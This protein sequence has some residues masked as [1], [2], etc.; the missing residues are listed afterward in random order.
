MK[1]IP[2]AAYDGA[3]VLGPVVGAFQKTVLGAAGQRNAPGADELVWQSTPAPL[4]HPAPNRIQVEI[5]SHCNMLC[6]FCAYTYRDRATTPDQHMDFVLF[7]K[8]IDECKS[9]LDNGWWIN[10]VYL[11]GLGEPLLYDRFEDA[12]QYSR[13]TAPNGRRLLRGLSTNCMALTERKAA[14]ILD[15]EL[16]EVILS[17]DSIVKEEYER[18]RVGGK[19]ETVLANIDR[20]LAM[21]AARGAFAEKVYLQ[22]MAFWENRN[23]IVDAARFWLAKIDGMPN[24]VAHLKQVGHWPAIKMRPLP[25]EEGGPVVGK[26]APPIAF[27]DVNP[28]APGVPFAG[29]PGLE[30]IKRHD[31]AEVL[32]HPQLSLIRE[33]ADIRPSCK[34]WDNSIT[35]LASGALDVCCQNNADVIGVGNVRDHTMLE[36]WRGERW[37]RYRTLFKHGRFDSIPVCRD[38][39]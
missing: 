32:G 24:T 16:D 31:F 15:G 34:L 27:V 21:R 5:T 3:R 13:Y 17:C 19:L 10:K 7:Q 30:F 9:Y 35:I 14:Q 25:P 12:L 33:I 39:R 23:S 38:C 28:E 6:P 20:F 26:G 29:M 22:T 2:G 18:L 8:V 11:Y 37:Q 1:A 4:E 36:L